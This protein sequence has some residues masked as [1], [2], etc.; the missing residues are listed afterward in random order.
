[1]AAQKG[2][3]AK[4]VRLQFAPANGIGVKKPC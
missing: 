1:L 3:Y 4:L 2:Y